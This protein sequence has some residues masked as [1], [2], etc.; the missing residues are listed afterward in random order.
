MNQTARAGLRYRRMFIRFAF[1]TLCASTLWAGDQSGYD[2]RFGPN[3]FL[4]S[5][6]KVGFDGFLKPSD[7][8]TAEYCGKCH[9]EAHKEWRQS[10][11]ANSFRA[12]FYVKN[13]NLLIDSKGIE[14]SRHCE[15]CH[16]PIALFSGAL[17]KDS[18]INRSFDE[19]GVTCMVCH[20]IQKIQNTS[21]TGSYVMGVPAVMVNPDG[22]PVT[23]AVSYDD[24]FL[25][26]EQHKRAVMRDFYRTPEFC[27]VC[28]K[29]ALPRILNGYKWLR[30]FSVYDEWQQ[31]SWSKESPLPFYKK[32]EVSTCQTCHMPKVDAMKDYGSEQG[33]IASHR[34]LGANTAI[35]VFYGFDEQLQKIREYLQD[36]ILGID[37]FALNK[38]TAGGE[39]LVAPI[40]GQKFTLLPGETVT[41]NV[42][43]QNKKIGHSLVPEQR[44]FYESWVEFTAQDSTGR[45]F[46]HSGFL[47]P[48]GF[49]EP[50]AHS[51]T[52]RLVS[53]S[54]KLLDL[55]QVWESKV[56]TYDNT[57]LPGRS[58]LVRYKFW[59]PPDAK[60]PLKLT[61][62]VNYRRFRKGFTNFI[63]PEAREFPIVTMASQSSALNLG[64]NEGTPTTDPQKL[65][66]RW[67]NYGIALLGQQQYWLASQA[68]QKVVEIQPSYA[69]GYMNIAIAEYS[70]LI[71]N[72]RESPD[73]PG[74]LSV[75]NP[76]YE[77]F[78]PA[79]KALER[80]LQISPGNFRALYYQGL[81]YR[82]Q[83]R[84][85]QAIRNQQL[86][87]A[88]YSRFRQARQE[89]GY[90][91]YLQKKYEP[92]REQFEALQGINPDDLTA[93]YYLSLIYDK[94]GMTQEALEQGALYAEQKD[95]PTVGALAQDFWRDHPEVADEL[96]PFHVHEATLKKK[97]KTTIGGVLP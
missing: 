34:F 47:D 69:D 56:K 72:K 31:S 80:A 79:L 18:K 48:R 29:A 74:N 64:L 42:V 95:D 75:S 9:E 8:P 30:A 21:G 94:L 50:N 83:N 32:D 53:N 14:Y 57:I 51:Y 81:V 97:R 90:A 44:D 17:T 7:F 36:N 49:L 62:Q 87:I 96:E 25:H 68:F 60:G 89:L 1:L 59:I 19:D 73:G 11:H 26:P 43:I 16:N 70:K 67:N 58:D 39:H 77:K 37:I 40:D 2:H 3:P 4:P 33:K 41:V 38:Q 45:I 85:D 28:H 35:P 93:H 65:M 20:S 84:L 91:Y 76:A 86:V 22:T 6:A 46:Y 82:L 24:I 66:L 52:N 78:A 92:A 88:A 15:G 13:V 63:F 71:E 12:P 23:S 5:N 10:A 55:H 54:G 61:A 27:A